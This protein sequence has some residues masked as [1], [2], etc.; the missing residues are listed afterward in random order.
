MKTTSTSTIPFSSFSN[1]GVLSSSATIPFSS[2]S[3]RRKRRHNC[4]FS[5][6]K[7]PPQTPTL[8]PNCSDLGVARQVFDETPNRD[9]PIFAWNVLMNE[10]AKAGDLDQCLSLFKDMLEHGI[11]G[12]P[13]T[14]SC[15]L[16]C[17]ASSG[18]VSEG[19]ALHGYLVKSGF[20]SYVAV[21]NALIT[22]YS[23]RRRIDSALCLFE[24]MLKR[25][26]VS[27]NSIMSGCISN[28]LAEKAIGLLVKMRLWGI[29][30]DAMTVI[31]VLR[32]CARTCFLCFG[33]AVHGYSIKSRFVEEANVSNS[34]IDMYGKCGDSDSAGR[35]F[36][37]M[38]RR[39]AVSWTSMISV[40]TRDGRFDEAVDLF[41]R[42]EEE[43][44]QP[45]AFAVSSVLHACTLGG[46]LEHRRDVH[47]Q[48]IR[49]GLESDR[50]VAN[51][52]IDMYAKCGSVTDARV[53]F[54]RIASTAKDVVT[55]NAMIGGYSKNSLTNEALSLF[56]EMMRLQVKPNCVTITCVLPACASL[57]SLEQGREVHGH[58][59][60]I[61]C[62]SDMYVMNALMDM[63]TKSGALDLACAL[64]DRMEAKDLLSW[65]V[66]IAGYSMHGHGG[67]ALVTFKAMRAKAIE[68]NAASFLAILRA[69]SH[70]GLIEEGQKFFDAMREE[71]KIEP[72][73]EH[74]SC[75]V[76]L[77]SRAGRLTEAYSFIESMAV[78]PN[79]SVWTPLLRGCQAHQDVKLAEKVAERIFELEPENAEHYMLLANV[80]AEAVRW[81]ATK[82][83]IERLNRR[84]GSSKGCSWIEIRGKAQ[85]LLMGTTRHTPNPRRS[86]H[87]WRAWD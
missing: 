2:V 79:S 57:S 54:D 4:V 13:H 64:F 84:K 23:K 18:S 3:T 83:F 75:M 85:V 59:L 45:D 30:A 61:G 21:G 9:R 69:C 43:G 22:F 52:L 35:V 38:Y 12:N 46:S 73:M 58:A 40:Y 49:I 42:M 6:S 77:L 34:L 48:I 33:R 39:T 82:K 51:A 47:D 28:N 74:Y 62:Y 56:G 29:D 1:Y 50:V 11:Q 8:P 10:H 65:T 66:I 53:V 81:N 16:K 26:V 20:I 24:G 72:E 55:W 78:K 15:V 7:P 5:S 80:Y 68:P 67:Q 17:L 71:C 87:C 70:S 41:K 32:A 25:D 31:C 63:Y 27:W 14:F 76:D 86:G 36:R 44:V 19:A 37:C 60:R